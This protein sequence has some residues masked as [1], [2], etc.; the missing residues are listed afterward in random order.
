MFN[1]FIVI[2]LSRVVCRYLL[3]EL[4]LLVALSEC[5]PLND[6]PVPL[7]TQ[8]LQLLHQLG[9]VEGNPVSSLSLA[10]QLGVQLPHLLLVHLHLM[11]LNKFLHTGTTG[12]VL[13]Y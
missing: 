9:V 7:H 13:E 11:E 8:R 3:N 6:Q 1:D 10:A 4:H 12:T 2:I 5:V